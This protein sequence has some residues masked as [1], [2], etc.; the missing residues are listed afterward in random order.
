MASK[1]VGAGRILL[2]NFSCSL[3]SSDI[4]RHTLFVPLIHEVVRYMRP[5]SALCNSFEAGE[6]CSMTL[7]GVSKKSQFEFKKPSGK[8]TNG[9]IEISEDEA[10]VFFPMSDECGFYSVHVDKK[11]AGSVAVNVNSLESNLDTLSAEQLTRLSR[12]PRAQFY[13]SIAS[14]SALDNILEGKHL[15]H[16]FLI[17]A[18]GL[19]A[20]EQILV[21]TLRK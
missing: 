9:N 21:V 7:K 3:G 13:A 15:W 1:G 11:L 12:I 8:T 14:A 2:C 20:L 4:A 18:M 19:L 5:D 10:A 16:Y 17:A 6:Q